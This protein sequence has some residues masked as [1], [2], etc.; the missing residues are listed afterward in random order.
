V[1]CSQRLGWGWR[2]YNTVGHSESS[3]DGPRE[4]A[5]DQKQYESRHAGLLWSKLDTPGILDELKPIKTDLFD[6][7]LAISTSVG[8]ALA[9]RS[10]RHLTFSV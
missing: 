1:W 6:L 10:G 3:I 8:D 5:N 7:L 4:E 2:H 9:L